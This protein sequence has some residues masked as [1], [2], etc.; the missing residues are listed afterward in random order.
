MSLDRLCFHGA[1]FRGGLRVDPPVELR[2]ELLGI[3]EGGIE[4]VDGLFV[5]AVAVHSA[6]EVRIN[7]S[8]IEGIT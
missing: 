7:F 1:F 2:N 5:E 4:A 8:C 3:M 6:E